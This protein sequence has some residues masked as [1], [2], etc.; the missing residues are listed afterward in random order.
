MLTVFWWGRGLFA[1]LKLIEHEKKPFR[2]RGR[3]QVAPLFAESLSD[4]LDRR[5]D[6]GW[7]CATPSVGRSR[8]R[9]SLRYFIGKIAIHG[10]VAAL[11]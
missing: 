7:H 6:P 3:H 1:S 4:C 11:L 9:E 8:A 5:V 2:Q 10:D